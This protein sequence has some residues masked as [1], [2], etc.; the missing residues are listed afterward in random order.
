MMKFLLGIL[1]TVHNEQSRHAFSVLP[2]FEENAK[3]F[4][5]GFLSDNIAGPFSPEKSCDCFLKYTSSHLSAYNY[6]TKPS[7]LFEKK[8]KRDLSGKKKESLLVKNLHYV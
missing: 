8:K 1:L 3:L 2:M 5:Q 7:F 4:S 6:Q